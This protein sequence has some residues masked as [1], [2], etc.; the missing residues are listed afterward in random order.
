MVKVRVR[1]RVRAMVRV[2]GYGL[3]TLPVASR[4][5]FACGFELA[6]TPVA[7]T[8][9]CFFNITACVRVCMYVC[10]SVCVCVCV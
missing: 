1:V 4:G 5:L 3:L 6:R 7:R 2:R 8:A 9:E 10:V